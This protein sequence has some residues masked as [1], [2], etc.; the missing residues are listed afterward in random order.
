MH[1]LTTVVAEPCGGVLTDRYATRAKG[2]ERVGHLLTQSW[3]EQPGRRGR[4]ALCG[5][6]AKTWKPVDLFTDPAEF[7][8]CGDCSTTAGIEL[9]RPPVR[10]APGSPTPAQRPG[11]GPDYT[12]VEHLTQTDR[13]QRRARFAAAPVPLTSE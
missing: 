4:P 9:P 7:R 1:A 11:P 3:T 13:H 8:D 10:F 2:G 6:R 5:V 12:R